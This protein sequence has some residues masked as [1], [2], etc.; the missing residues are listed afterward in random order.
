[1]RKKSI[2]III[3]TLI[4]MIVVGVG[5]IYLNPA[6]LLPRPGNSNI[7]INEDLEF[8]ALSSKVIVL[9]SKKDNSII[10]PATIE[11]F[12]IDKSRL[13]LIQKPNKEFLKFNVNDKDET[14]FDESERY[15]W[16]V[17]LKNNYVENLY[18]EEDFDKKYIEL[19]KVLNFKDIK[20]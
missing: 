8:T 7:K 6:I 9:T 10:V 3:I 15:V 11:K 1:M 20:F 2:K 13:Y 5:Y 19:K 4:L 16:I 17:D 18:L 14:S 12:A